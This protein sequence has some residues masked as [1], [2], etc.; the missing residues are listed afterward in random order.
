MRW[1]F[2]AATPRS[3][4]AYFFLGGVLGI[5]LV[6]GSQGQDC[7]PAMLLLHMRR[8]AARAGI[9]R[10]RHK[11]PASADFNAGDSDRRRS[12]SGRIDYSPLT[13]EAWHVHGRGFGAS[14]KLLSSCH[15]LPSTSRGPGGQERLATSGVLDGAAILGATPSRVGS[16]QGAPP[17]SLHGER[18]RADRVGAGEHNR[19]LL[20]RLEGAARTLLLEGASTRVRRRGVAACA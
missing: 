2:L 5:F 7:T 14:P 12:A 10:C 20:H 6:R 17:G 18:K 19:Q 8:P 16:V 15:V 11:S 4:P 9:S 3:S 1:A 13:K